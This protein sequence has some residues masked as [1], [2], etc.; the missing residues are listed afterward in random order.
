MTENGTFAS[1]VFSLVSLALIGLGLFLVLRPFIAPILW[2]GLLAL[3]LFPANRT[4]CRGLHGRRGLAAL[5]LTI[6]VVL[7]VVIPAIMLVGTFFMQATDLIRWLRTTASEHHIAQLSD[8][9]ALP[10]VD[11]VVQWISAR[12]PISG[13]QIQ[14]TAVAGGEQ[15]I[16][17]LLGLAGSL[18]TGVVGVAVNVVLSVLLLF[19][20]LRDGEEIVRR[21]LVLIPVEERRK[22]HLAAH[23]SAVTRGVVLGSLATAIVQGILVGV[24]FAIVGLRSPIVFAVLAMMASLVPFVGAALVWVPAA[25]ALLLQGSWGAA[26]FLTVWCL[27][28]VHSAD[29]VI[30]P[31]FVSSHAKISTL[32]VFIGLFGGVTA[33]GPI[34]MFLGP[35]LVALVL[36]LLDYAEESRVEGVIP[37]DRQGV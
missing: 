28:I 14:R 27:A 20:F 26:L 13:D 11:K 10:A 31:L 24:A 34:G 1:R 2:A 15:L 29:N 8:V 22:A 23:L 25:I 19:F 21:G 9:M 16:Q 12:M 35:V 30:R 18:F 37:E 6:A 32:P 3:L 17:G 5:L 36:A 7:I 4:L 33:F